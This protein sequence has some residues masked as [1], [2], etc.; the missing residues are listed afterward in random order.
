MQPEDEERFALMSLEWF[1]QWMGGLGEVETDALIVFE[2]PGELVHD[3]YA[4]RR[5][6]RDQRRSWQGRVAR[7]FADDP[8]R[9]FV[10]VSE[11][12]P[13]ACRLRPVRGR[14][15][16]AHR[17]VSSN[18]VRSVVPADM[19]ADEIAELA[20]LTHQAAATRTAT[21]RSFGELSRPVWC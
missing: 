18:Q 16:F 8:W 2:S 13:D 11:L 6:G 20:E 21:G 5:L 9:R 19:G 14:S 17:H 7:M 3:G 12:S 4:W 1:E 15:P 10:V